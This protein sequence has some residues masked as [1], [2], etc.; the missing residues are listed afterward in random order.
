MITQKYLIIFFLYFLCGCAENKNNNDIPATRNTV[1]KK[2]VASYIIPMGDPKLDRKFGAEIFET[3][4]TFKYFL[5]MYFD[6]TVENDTLIIPNLGIQPVVQIKPGDEKLS[7]II[8]FADDKNVFREYKSLA[9]KN[10]QMR[11]TTLK[12]YYTESPQ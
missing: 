3:P 11:L 12:K 4:E 8:G 10:N 9:V 1:N 7:C 6:G 2:P 5:V